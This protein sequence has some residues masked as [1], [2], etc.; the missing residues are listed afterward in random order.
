M[1]PAL[2]RLLLA[3]HVMWLVDRW[4]LIRCDYIIIISNLK[5]AIRTDRFRLADS[6]KH[7]AQVLCFVLQF[8][9]ES[10]DAW[11]S[12]CDW[13]LLGLVLLKCTIG[14]MYLV[15]VTYAHTINQ[16]TARDVKSLDSLGISLAS[17]EAST[18]TS[19]DVYPL[20]LFSLLLL[21][22]FSPY[23]FLILGSGHWASFVSLT[24]GV[25]TLKPNRF[26]NGR[27]PLKYQLY[28]LWVERFGELHCQMM[29]TTLGT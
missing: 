6:S 19:H 13:L 28:P 1:V 29:S 17:I 4:L 3:V 26:S 2:L 22:L 15:L 16:I 10:H 7:R 14:G 23:L 24:F 20:D 25:A 8:K 5:R 9:M 21:P 11:I 12:R 18:I 27:P